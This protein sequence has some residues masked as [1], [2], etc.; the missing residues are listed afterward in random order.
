MAPPAK[1]ELNFEQLAADEK[2]A[3]Q[4]ERRR[5]MGDKH[6][7]NKVNNIQGSNAG[8]GS[9][10]FHTYRQFRRTEMERLEKMGKDAK[11]DDQKS[12]FDK[13]RLERA[14]AEEEKTA[15]RAAKRRKKKERKGQSKDGENDSDGEK[16]LDLTKIKM[17]AAPRLTPTPG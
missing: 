8:A 7:A 16:E 4:D 12:E 11:E 13:G 15:G 9:G 1:E 10:D 2:K 6:T 14:Q 17:C 5:L 3:L